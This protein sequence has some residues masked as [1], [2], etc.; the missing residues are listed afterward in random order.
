MQKPR[1]LCCCIIVQ[2]CTSGDKIFY[3]PITHYDAKRV[4]DTWKFYANIT[5]GDDILLIGK[6]FLSQFTNDASTTEL[7]NLQA[8]TVSLLA[9]S[10]FCRTYSA[11]INAEDSG[12]YDAL[13]DNFMMRYEKMKLSTSMPIT[14]Q[15][16]VD[17]G[18]LE[19]TSLGYA[20]RND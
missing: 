18:W 8:E 12:R 11:K 6:T 2:W 1:G 7:N 10:I 20:W 17:F 9:A 13:A 5:E 4:D 14:L 16:T 19:E 3:Y 15:P